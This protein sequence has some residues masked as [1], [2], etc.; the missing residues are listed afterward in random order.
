MIVSKQ[1]VFSWTGVRTYLPYFA[2][3]LLMLALVFFTYRAVPDRLTRVRLGSSKASLRFE[4]PE[5]GFTARV[6]TG[7]VT[8]E[9]VSYDQQRLLVGA[10]LVI[11]AAPLWGPTFDPA[12]FKRLV[13]D[14]IPPVNIV[15]RAQLGIRAMRAAKLRSA[16]VIALIAIGIAIYVVLRFRLL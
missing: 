16:L 13:V 7:E 4:V 5:S 2:G 3:V 9:Q 10:Q 15:S 1:A 11:V 6:K 8:W 12:E 14:R